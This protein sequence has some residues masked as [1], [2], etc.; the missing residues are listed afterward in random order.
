[1]H[2][3]NTKYCIDHDELF[4]VTGTEE[5]VKVVISEKRRKILTTLLPITNRK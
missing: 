2:G 5:T 3:Y 4:K 1:M